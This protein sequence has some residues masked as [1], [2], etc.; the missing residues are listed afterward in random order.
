MGLVIMKRNKETG[1][2]E[3]VEY[4][5]K[6]DGTVDWKAMLKPEHFYINKEKQS[7]IERVYK[8]PF[9]ELSPLE[10]DEKYLAILLPGIKY[11]AK[12]RGMKKYD[13]QIVNVSYDPY[14]HTVISVSAKASIIWI[15]NQDTDF[16]E[17]EFG[18]CGGANFNNTKGVF[19]NYLESIATNRAFVRAVRN[20]L[21]IDIIAKDE[22]GENTLVELD[23]VPTTS[24]SVSSSSTPSINGFSPQIMLKQQVDKMENMNFAKFKTAVLLRHSAKV[25]EEAKNWKSFDDINNN[26]CYSLLTIIKEASSK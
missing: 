26:D 9:E 3:G 7:E 5:F 1:L 19:R 25:S 22:L 23:E 13:P 2:C 11:L 15:G 18:D 20:Y 12:L 24:N 21:G 4:K 8:K 16:V 14:Y 6:E 10:V 17:E